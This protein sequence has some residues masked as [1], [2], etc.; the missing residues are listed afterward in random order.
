MDTGG[1]NFKWSMQ[2]IHGLTQM[3][4]SQAVISPGSRSTPVTLA[5][6][7][8]PRIKTHVQID[9]RCAGFFALGLAQQS[10][11]PVLLICTSGTAVAN[12]YPAIIEASYSKT[13]LILFSA[14]RP[15]ELQNCGANQTINQQ[16]MFG[17]HVRY[18]F[19]IDQ[20]ESHQQSIH[21]LCNKTFKKSIHPLPG[22]VHINRPFAEPLLPETADTVSID[23]HIMRITHD[24][25][26]STSVEEIEVQTPEKKKTNSRN[27][28]TLVNSINKGD[29]LIICGH[30]HYSLNFSQQLTSLASHIKAPLLA[31]PLS[32][33]RFGHHEK[34]SLIYNYDS[35]FRSQKAQQLKPDWILRFGSFPVSKALADFLSQQHCDSILIEAHGQKLD[36]IHRCQQIIQADASDICQQLNNKITK[37]SQGHLLNQLKFMDNTCQQVIDNHIQLPQAELDELLIIHELLYHV[38]DDCILFSGNS[39]PIRDINSF[40]TGYEHGNKNIELI[41]NRGAS[42]IDGNLSAFAGHM[43]HDKNRPAIA[44]IGDL[45]FYHDLNGLL[46]LRELSQ[47][48]YNGTVIILNNN[49]GSIFSYLSQ[50]ALSDFAPFWLTST[51]LNFKHAAELYSLKYHQVNNHRQLKQALSESLSNKH[52]DI[53]EIHLHRDD[54]VKMHRQLWQHIIQQLDS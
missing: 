11:K 34:N 18:F 19:S 35:I 36:P 33:L 47:Q 50:Q 42:G 2:F 6:I 46:K 28:E 40:M 7:K 37:I 12:W 9:E 51:D 52:V 1:H 25:I 41:G 26:D 16:H 3:G 10:A 8:H 27:I 31:D 21:L 49:G 20:R 53:I 23:E 15:Q 38:P 13:P 29:G 43:V 45:T 17:H 30:D 24:I 5:C 22:P 4:I 39:M 44:L 32:R 48:A 14:D 54:S